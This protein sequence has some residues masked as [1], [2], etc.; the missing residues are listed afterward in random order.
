MTILFEEL[1]ILQA[2]EE[3]ADKLWNSVMKWDNFSNLKLCRPQK[4][5]YSI[6]Q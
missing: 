4:I 2:V 6:T 3:V 5:D 1:R